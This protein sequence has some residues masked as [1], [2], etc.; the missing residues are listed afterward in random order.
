MIYSMNK[1]YY[2]DF[3]VVELGKM[4][5]RAYFIPFKTMDKLMSTDFVTE[6]YNSDAVTV[7]NGEWDFRYYAD[8]TQL[9]DEVDTD[10][11]TFDKVTVPS[12]WQRTGYEPPCYLNTRFPFNNVD[13]SIYPSVPDAMPRR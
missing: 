2:K 4:A 10:K 11:L 12:T 8:C 13:N 5:A 7:L 9:E 3:S 1:K 6:R